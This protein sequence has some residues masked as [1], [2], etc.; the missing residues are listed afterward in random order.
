VTEDD[1]ARGERG[2]RNRSGGGDTF[3][4]RVERIVSSSIAG[5]SK[6]PRTARLAERIKTG[7]ISK[8]GFVRLLGRVAS[9]VLLLF[10][11]SHSRRGP[12]AF[13]EKA[14]DRGMATAGRAAMGVSQAPA[15]LARPCA[16]TGSRLVGKAGQGRT[17][18]RGP[19]PAPALRCKEPNMTDPEI[20]ELRARCI[21]PSC[22]SAPRRCGSSTVR[23]ALERP[24]F[25]STRILRS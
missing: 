18:T 16:A 19:G 14:K 3:C 7:W 2:A 23:K 13:D 6:S 17:R 1:V 5:G 10:E 8:S 11:I 24:A 22:L 9:S 25:G 20:E 4:A 15:H 21:A 12:S